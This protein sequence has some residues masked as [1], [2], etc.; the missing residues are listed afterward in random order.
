M[1][2]AVVLA[3]GP[4][5]TP[6]ELPAAMRT[7]AA[8]VVAPAKDSLNT[9]NDLPAAMRAPSPKAAA[10]VPLDMTLAE[11]EKEAIFQA[12]AHTDGN[13]ASAAKMLGLSE[14]TLYRKLRLFAD[15]SPAA[16]ETNPEPSSR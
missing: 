1:E 5:I 13:R 15:E 12:L 16:Q 10:R 6:N 8:T 2:R 4:V 14:R 9:T 3:K 7:A 11:M